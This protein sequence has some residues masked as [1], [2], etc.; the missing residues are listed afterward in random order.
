MVREYL[1]NNEDSIFIFWQ[2]I[3]LL[4]FQKKSQN[5]IEANIENWEYGNGKIEILDF[6]SGKFQEFVT[7][8]QNGNLEIELANF[9]QKKKEQRKKEQEKALEGWEASLKNFG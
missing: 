9:L 2:F 6:I 8:D 3:F 7:I 1:K 5:L 4:N